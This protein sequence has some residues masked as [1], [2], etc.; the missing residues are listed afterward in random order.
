[1]PSFFLSF[2]VP[3]AVKHQNN[4]EYVVRLHRVR[5]IFQNVSR[6]R[7]R[8]EGG[9]VIPSPVHILHNTHPFTWNVRP[10]LIDS[11]NVVNVGQG[12]P[13][14]PVAIHPAACFILNRISLCYV[15]NTALRDLQQLDRLS[16]WSIVL[17]TKSLDGQKHD[18]LHD[19]ALSWYCNDGSVFAFS[20][21][22]YPSFETLDGGT[23]NRYN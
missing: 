22:S 20:D 1:M 9:I 15:I 7:E 14:L 17:V 3:V 23:I 4:P 11:V 12:T 10:W 19:N 18:L 2:S 13:P 8:G 6:L 21:V 16:L 5:I